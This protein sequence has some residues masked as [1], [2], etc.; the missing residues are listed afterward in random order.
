MRRGVRKRTVVLRLKRMQVATID[1]HVTSECSQEC[2]YCWGPQGIR[3]IRTTPARGIIDRVA[4]FGIRRIVFTGGDPLQQKDT[5][6]LLHH[7]KGRGLE[8]ALSTTGDRLT[9]G[10]LRRYGRDIDL[11]SLP[12]DGSCE[13]VNALTKKPGHFG[14]VMRALELLG[15]HPHIDVKLCTPVTKAN[16]HDVANIAA[17]FDQW[18]RRVH[19]RGFYNVFQTFPR[20]MKP[21][22]WSD[23]LVSDRQFRAVKW[24]I[25]ARRFAIR[26]NF[27]S[28]RTL[29]RLYVMIFPDGRLVVPSG[30]AYASFGKFLEIEDLDAALTR[31]TFA[32]AKHLRHSL[33]YSSTGAPIRLR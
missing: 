5:G 20:A 14:A 33:A 27:F 25:Q 23:W 31:S 17:L 32:V 29:D 1:F 19:N 13:A 15:R 6:P 18:A 16:L 4:E 2:P 12:L 8:V 30:P 7:A 24:E 28:R 26:V 3:P 11:I 21:V 10:F 22:V 9:P